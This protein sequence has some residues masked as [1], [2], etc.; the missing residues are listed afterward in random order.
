MALPMR[1]MEV[2]GDPNLYTGFTS[3]APKN[4][5][6]SSGPATENTGDGEP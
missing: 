4:P 2:L 3:Q 1:M 6:L 5:E